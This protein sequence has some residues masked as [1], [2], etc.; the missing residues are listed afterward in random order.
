MHHLETL[1]LLS[2]NIASKAV[3]FS[4]VAKLIP[5]SG[6]EVDAILCNGNYLLL[7]LG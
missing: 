7:S 3:Y 2:L 6:L 1:L 4:V 5:L